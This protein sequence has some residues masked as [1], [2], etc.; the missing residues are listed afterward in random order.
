MESSHLAWVVVS[1][2]KL[3]YNES[4]AQVYEDVKGVEEA[5]FSSVHV[6]YSAYLAS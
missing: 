2:R 6:Y 5:L 1:T 4:A 3:F